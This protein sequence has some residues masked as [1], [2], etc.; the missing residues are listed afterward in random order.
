MWGIDILKYSNVCLKACVFSHVGCLSLSG[1][2]EIFEAGR[3]LTEKAKQ[4][5]KR[6]QKVYIFVGLTAGSQNVREREREKERERERERERV[7]SL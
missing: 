7:L 2:D 3:N 1:C 4:E 6:L 5:R